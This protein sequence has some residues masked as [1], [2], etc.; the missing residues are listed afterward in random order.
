ML[1]WTARRQ[2]ETAKTLSQIHK[3]AAREESK[4]RRSNSSNSLR[5]SSS[6]GSLHK[7]G[8]KYNRQKQ[9]PIQVDADGFTVVPKKKV[10]TFRSKFDAS[11][12]NESKKTDA[13]ETSVGTFTALGEI[14]EK[15]ELS[16]PDKV[17]T[18]KEI[19]KS[20]ENILKEFFVGG[21]EDDAILSIKELIGE[22]DG[23]VERTTAVLSGGC[24]SI[25][26]MKQAEVDKFVS[27]I[28]NLSS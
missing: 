14:D 22:G 18:E 19:E 13:P 9:E 23:A 11:D 28:C 1:G 6:S 16:I 3:E 4:M 15:P 12:S 26:E 17:P 27:F 25:M 2:I 10:N 21:D 5:R 20:M 24:L 7:S 8:K